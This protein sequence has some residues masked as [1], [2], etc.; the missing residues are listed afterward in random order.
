[1]AYDTI[2]VAESE[3]AVTVTLN[4]P[5]R[6]NALTDTMLAELHLALEVAERLPDCRMVV[7]EGAN[8]FFCT[9][10]DL[11]ECAGAEGTTQDS[12][13]QRARF[14]KLLK[15]F[16]VTPRVVVSVVDGR[17]AGGGVGLAAASDFVFASER[18]QFSLPEALWGLLP[19]SVAPFLQRR[20]GFQL[21]YAMTL[22]TLPISARHAERVGL[23][24]EVSADP[25]I[26]LRR[27]ACRVEKLK[28]A[29]IAAAKRYFA[30]LCPIGEEVESAALSEFDNLFASPSVQQAIAG[31]AGPYRRFPWER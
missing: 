20:V 30:R 13:S 8:G 12:P 22:S 25:Y 23:V 26:P 6:Q 19:C 28:E 7:I 10:M 18:A 1:M 21:L 5:K 29:T 15:R 11:E 3:Q 24:D 27:L 9:G 17:A 31:F 2:L 4:R 14:F 16:T